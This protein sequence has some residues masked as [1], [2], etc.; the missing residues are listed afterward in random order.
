LLDTVGLNANAVLS[1]EWT[2]AKKINNNYKKVRMKLVQNKVVICRFMD[3]T[4]TPSAYA[5]GTKELPVV[6]A[7]GSMKSSDG[8][9]D[10]T[11]LSILVMDTVIV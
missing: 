7:E 6:L 8:G 11:A 3:T 9:W 5:T 4:P 10:C 1:L 2:F